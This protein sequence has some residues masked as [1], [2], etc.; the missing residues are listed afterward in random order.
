MGSLTYQP[1]VRP[2][3][4]VSEMMLNK[5]LQERPEVGPP[6][7]SGIREYSF[8]DNPLLLKHVNKSNFDFQICQRE[9]LACEA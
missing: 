5:E 2:H 4:H 8:L 7:G 3:D 9:L 1:L 6:I